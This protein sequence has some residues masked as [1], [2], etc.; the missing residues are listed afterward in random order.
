MDRYTE[1][2]EKVRVPT[3][4]EAHR[5]MI[6]ARTVWAEFVKKTGTKRAMTCAEWGVLVG[7]M[8]QD[9]P[10]RIVLRALD[11]TKGKGRTLVYYE[12]PVEAA[13]RHWARA[14]L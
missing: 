10:L 5:R 8:D 13:A 6:Y 11:D 12:K 3:E 2:S 9:I 4:A 7:W 14:V 1:P